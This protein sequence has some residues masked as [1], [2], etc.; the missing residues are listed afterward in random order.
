MSAKKSFDTEVAGKK[1]LVTV[2][3]LA[4]QAH[5]SCT[6]QYGDTKVLATTVQAREPRE[7]IDFFPL[8][9]DYEERLYAAG[10]IKGSRFIKREG[11]PTDEAVLTG[12]M[13]DRSIRPLFKGTERKD[14]QVMITVLSVD[15]ANDPDVPSLIAAAIALGISPVPWNGP[16]AAVRV[17]RVDNEWVLNPA[18][19]ARAKSQLDIVVAGTSVDVVMIEGQG[20]EA[21]ENI[22]QEA[23]AFGHKHVAKLVP[24]IVK[25]IKEVGKN[26]VTPNEETEETNKI[27]TKV[28]D[29]LKP[30]V[31][32]L[33]TKT[34]RQTYHIKVDELK[35]ELED[36]LKQDNEVNKD[37]RSLGL[38]IFEDVLD[39]SARQM[40][41]QKKVRVDGRQLNEIRPLEA[42]VGVLP[43]TH[44][45]GLFQRGET[46]V[47][48]VVTLAAPSAEQTLDGMEEAG[49]KRYMHHYNFPGFS[50]GEVSPVRS[51]GRREVGHGALAEKALVPVLPD[52]EKFPYTIRVVSEVLSSNGSS[53]QASVCGSSLALMDAG[54]PITAPVAGIAM[55]LLADP[56]DKTNYA[57]ITDI[58]GIEDHAGDM[59]F[60]IA[61]TS[62]GITAIQLDIKLGG[63]SLEILNEAIDQAKTAR[64]KVLKVMTQA[65]PEPRADLSPYAPRI[66]SLRIPPDKIRD[67][68][69]PGGKVINEIIDATGVQIDIEDDG[70]VMVTAVDQEASAKAIEWIKNLT[71]QVVVGEIY[72]GKVTRLM[73]F[74]AFVEILP[75][76]EGLVHISELAWHRV[77][78][79]DDVVKVGDSLKVKVIEIDD[80]GRINLSHKQTLPKPEGIELNPRPSGRPYN[81]RP[82]N[83]GFKNSHRNH[84][85]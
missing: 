67:V 1:L 28:N 61:G 71:R 70:L 74:G 80:Q 81:D 2:G 11:R 46:Q 68:I 83:P 56:D 26:K 52:K 19:E 57:V 25:I 84:R 50:V 51:P 47:L 55:G 75:K 13:I 65:I 5:G 39:V 85:Y 66:T 6:V 32:D 82:R 20:S 36:M 76:Q 7:G 33:F 78:K 59:D 62:K 77:D 38:K 21:P 4:G 48:S 54:V 35:A 79:V 43:R 53:S 8:L 18:Y 73:N 37:G 23:I 30:K 69:G 58:Q 3:E 64:A 12:R 29:W 42:A 72:E 40:V 31:S 17:G 10:K 60:K 49:K 16:I 15:Q 14:V 27:K 63:V 9:V 22:I 45:S 24:W 34:N 41:L 44:G